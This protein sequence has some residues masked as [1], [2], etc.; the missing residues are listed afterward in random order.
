MHDYFVMQ[1][2]NNNNK[3]K[4]IIDLLSSIFAEWNDFI[5]SMK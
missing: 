2:N 5:D 3:F 1:T 4:V